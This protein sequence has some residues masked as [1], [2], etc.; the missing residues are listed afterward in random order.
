[1]APIGSCMF[2]TSTVNIAG[3]CVATWFIEW[4]VVFLFLCVYVGGCDN[5]R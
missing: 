4:C 5:V 1:M 3:M 2:F